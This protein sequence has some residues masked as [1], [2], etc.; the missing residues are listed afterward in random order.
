MIFM[1]SEEKEIWRVFKFQDIL[2][3]SSFTVNR[4]PIKEPPLKFSLRFNR[5]QQIGSEF[6]LDKGLTHRVL[7]GYAVVTCVLR[8]AA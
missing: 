3:F 2:T 5:S 6:L 8:Q 1:S 4:P 7:D